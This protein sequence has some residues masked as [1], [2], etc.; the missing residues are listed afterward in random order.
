MDKLKSMEMELENERLRQENKRLKEELASRRNPG[1]PTTS[2]LKQRLKK[3]LPLLVVLYVIWFFFSKM[4]VLTLIHF[5]PPWWIIPLG[6]IILFF[7]VDYLID[8]MM[9]D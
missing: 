5:H 9:H 3:A 4:R 7:A 8:K 1:S 2:S 6:L